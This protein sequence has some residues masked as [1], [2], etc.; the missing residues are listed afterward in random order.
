M[1]DPVGIEHGQWPIDLKVVI[2][3][4]VERVHDSGTPFVGEEANRI[5]SGRTGIVPPVEGGDEDRGS[6]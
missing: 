2:I 3:L 5:G 1:A 6:R 4:N